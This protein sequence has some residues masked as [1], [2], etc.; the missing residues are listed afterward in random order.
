MKKETKEGKQGI[1]LRL[2]FSAHE[3]NICSHMHVSVILNLNTVTTLNF[4][5]TKL[6]LKD[7]SFFL[8]IPGVLFY[9]TITL[10]TR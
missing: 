7:K 9:V 3:L 4:C 5:K 6:S 1:F 8:N 2:G 10:A